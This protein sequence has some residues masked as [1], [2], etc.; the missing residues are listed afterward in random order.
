[1]FVVPTCTKRANSPIWVT[2]FL[3]GIA[4]DRNPK[5]QGKSQEKSTSFA[6]WKAF[7]FYE[8]VGL[9]VLLPGVSARL[10]WRYPQLKFHISVLNTSFQ[11]VLGWNYSGSQQ[12]KCFGGCIVSTDLSVVYGSSIHGIVYS[13]V[14]RIARI[15]LC[16]STAF[17]PYSFICV[18][19]FCASFLFLLP[20]WGFS[21][22][23][24]LLYLIYHLGIGVCCPSQDAHW[25]QKNTWEVSEVVLITA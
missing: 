6:C 25:Q 20:F 12:L 10:S 22:L 19:R 5:F 14:F 21:C 13:F 16:I 7:N 3:W 9:T 18:L 23:V 1:M 8:R 15:Q 2:D 11:W 17:H 4:G 24:I